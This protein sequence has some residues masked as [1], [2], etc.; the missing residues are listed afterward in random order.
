MEYTITFTP[1]SVCNLLNRRYGQNLTVEQIE[2]QWEE[3]T[4]YIENWRYNGLM[5]ENLW[6]DFDT[7]SEEWGMNLFN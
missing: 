3:I 7:V 1:E 5:N 6:E 2:E 4:D